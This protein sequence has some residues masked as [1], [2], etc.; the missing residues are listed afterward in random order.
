MRQAGFLPEPMPK[1]PLDLNRVQRLLIIRLSSIGDVTHALPL[2]AALKAAYPHLEITWI[3][4]E[5]SA[6]IVTGN[7]ALQEVIIVPRSR[8]K[9]GR[10]RSPQVWREYRTFMQELRARRF[11]N[12]PAVAAGAEGAVD[13]DAAVMHVE[14][15]QRGGAEHGNM[16]G[17]SASGSRKAAAARHHSRAPGAP[18]PAI[19]EPSWPLSAR[20]FWVASASSLRKRPGSQ[21]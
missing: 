5:M 1:L 7:P 11:E 10:W 18:R 15:S 19:G 2:S 14:E 4:E 21:I 8:W 3:V 20:T 17:W 16:K 9:Q 6:E 12:Q 13:I